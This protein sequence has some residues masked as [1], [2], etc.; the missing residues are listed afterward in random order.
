[1]CINVA[2][3]KASNPHCQDNNQG[4]ESPKQYNNMPLHGKA[5]NSHCQNINQGNKLGI[6]APAQVQS[7][8][9]Q[10]RKLTSPEV[11]FLE[12][13]LFHHMLRKEE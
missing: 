10:P 9:T 2:L 11:R 6:T 5:S 8:V 1:M 12:E 3:G 7:Q 4:K 13:I